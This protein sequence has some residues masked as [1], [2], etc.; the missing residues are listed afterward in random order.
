MAKTELIAA[1]YPVFRD[2][3]TELCR[4]AFPGDG[5]YTDE[6]LCELMYRLYARLVEC[7]KKFNLTAILEYRAAAERHIVDSLML[8]HHLEKLNLLRDGTELLDIGAGA[9]FPSLPLA[10][11]SASGLFPH[12][13]VLAVDS[14][15]KK[16]GYI[17]ETA[18]LL[19]IR[20]IKAEAGRAEEL[21]RGEP[22]KGGALKGGLRGKF[23]VV[24]ARAVASLP[25]L[26]ELAA[27]F[28]KTGGTFAAMKAHAE[29]EISDAARGAAI[30]GLTDAE[31]IGYALP[32]GDRRTLVLYRA[33]RPAGDEYPRQYAKILHDPL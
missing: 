20:T 24:T 32:S 10:A 4:A 30:L 6:V 12:F 23:D 16:I 29:D 15:A 11:A 1:A 8:L 2:A 7:S 9:G 21:V 3:Y 19:G 13:S 25:V 5:R 28:L 31:E 17:K 18:E 26:L 14:T 27:P 22:R 33:E